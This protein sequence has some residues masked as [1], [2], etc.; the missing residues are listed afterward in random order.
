M[1][2][3]KIPKIIGASLPNMPWEDRPSDCADAVWRSAK[4][5]VIGRYEIPI[6]NSIY[7]S[8]AVPF[9][10]GF[11]GVFRVDDKSKNFRLHVGKSMDG[12]KWDIRSEP[13]E[14]DRGCILE[15]FIEGYDP[16]VVKLD[17]RYYVTWCDSYHGPLIGIAYTYDFEKF[18][19]LE[20]PFMPCCRNGVLFPRKIGGK[21]AMLN[22]P[23]DM[24]MTAFGDIFYLESPD[25]KYWGNCKYVMGP[26]TRS[27]Q[28][29]KVGA[30]PIPIETTEGWLLIYH[31]VWLNVNGYN[32]CMGAAIL[33]IDEPWKIKYRTK[34]YL[35]APSETYEM[36]GD[37]PN[38]IFP[39]ASL[40]DADT[41]RIAIYYGAADTVTGMA[42]TK[43]D[44]LVDFIKSNSL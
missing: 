12:Y 10:D 37:V 31:G 38:V 29:V 25:M 26:E 8:A 36:V 17:D 11:A 41:G 1:S 23:A 18:H 9:G 3:N 19:Q 22:R 28:H 20:Y 24:G 4:N 7:N 27:W 42:F 15:P 35:L 44:I 16:R 13:I 39:C 21:Y 30:G 5:P 43:L 32:Y 6:S 14:F 40:H 2:N 34:P 33:D